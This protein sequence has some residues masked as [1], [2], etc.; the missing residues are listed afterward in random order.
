[1]CI[2]VC[3]YMLAYAHVSQKR[4]SDFPGAAVIGSCKP[5]HIFLVSISFMLKSF[6]M[7]ALGWAPDLANQG[8]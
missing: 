7:H 4:A 6:K 5:Y 1:M 8:L 2:S 3:I